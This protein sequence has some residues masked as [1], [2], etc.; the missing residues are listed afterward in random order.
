MTQHETGSTL[1]LKS[2]REKIG[3]N[4]DMNSDSLIPDSL[5]FLHGGKFPTL[6]EVEDLL[7]Q[8]V[9]D[10][11]NGN[12]GVASTLLGISRQALNHHINRKYHHMKPS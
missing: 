10:Q 2:F 6:E 4:R 8:K 5:D 9:L 11:V 7:I 1:S 12:Q 3:G